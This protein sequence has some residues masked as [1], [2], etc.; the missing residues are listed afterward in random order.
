MYRVVTGDTFEAIARKEYGTEAEAARIRRANPGVSEPLVPGAQ[1]IAP[2]VPGAPKDKPQENPAATGNEVALLIDGSRFRFWDS[3]RIARSM[4]TMDTVEF[5]APFDPSAP[6][7]RETFRPFSYKSMEVKVG[8]EQLFSGTMVTV[9]PVMGVS[10]VTIAAGGYSTPGVL[11]DCTPP[12]PSYPIEF[13]GLD[14]SGIAEAIAGDFGIAVEFPDGPGP[15]FDRVA[16][17]P[18]QKA[19]AFLVELA[20]QRNLIVTN[21]PAGALVFFRPGRPGNPVARLRQGASPLRSVTPAFSP[22]QYHS[23]ITGIQPVVTGSEGS[24]YTVKNP[25]L[26]GTIRPISFTSQDSEGGDI[27]ASVGAKASRMFGAMASYSAEVSAWRG[28]N[29]DL[30]APGDAVTLEAP[31]AMVYDEYKFIIRTA[32]FRRDGGSETATLD[33]VVPGSFSG[34]LPGG[35][36]WEL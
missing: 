13:N 6:G 9:D 10:G 32:I 1:L 8:G 18:G 36:P 26:S 28:A 21:G 20:Q 25:R 31:D 4:D 23:H 7:M 2:A 5:G 11:N 19:L 15:E 34:E 30:W 14:L 29:G 27:A 3:V 24:Q 33:L 16:C 17:R 22:Q 12:A 35:L